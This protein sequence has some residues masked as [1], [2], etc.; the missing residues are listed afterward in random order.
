MVIALALVLVATDIGVLGPRTTGRSLDAEQPDQQEV[1]SRDL[2][3]QH[4]G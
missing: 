2:T 3:G 1:P 4:L